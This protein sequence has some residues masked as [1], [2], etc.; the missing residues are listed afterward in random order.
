M[1]GTLKLIAISA[2][3]ILAI[4]GMLA[5]FGFVPFDSLVDALRYLL[6]ALGILVALVFGVGLLAT[7]EK[8]A[9]DSKSHIR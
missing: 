2:L 6:P 3:I 7:P 5:V 9:E 4:L 1:K 8:G